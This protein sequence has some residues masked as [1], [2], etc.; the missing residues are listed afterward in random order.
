MAK[1]LRSF[2]SCGAFAVAIFT[3]CLHVLP[4][5]AVLVSTLAGSGG[6]GTVN[7]IGTQAS[8]NAPF[9][10]AISR[11]G[12]FALIGDRGNSQIRY[13]D[14]ISAQ[15]T[16]LASS[17][18]QPESIS[19]SPDDSF[20]LFTGLSQPYTIRK[21]DIATGIVTVLAGSSTSGTAD[22]FGTLATFNAPRGIAHS[23]DGTFAL[24]ADQ[25]SWR[26]RRIDVNTTNVTTVAGS[27]QGFFDGMGTNA[28][29]SWLMGV[30]IDPSGSYALIC[31]YGNNRIRR[32]DLVSA[33]VT[34]LAGSSQG[35]R[36]GVGG[37]AFFNEPVSVSID[38][39]GAYVLVAEFRNYRIRRIVISTAQVTTL[40]G[41]GAVSS[42]NGAGGQATFNEPTSIS[43]D[44]SGAFALLASGAGH[45]IR[46]I[47]L[48][49]PCP[50]A[51]FCSTGSSAPT[52]CST[53]SYCPAGSSSDTPCA[54]GLYCPSFSVALPCSAGYFCNATGLS[55]NNGLQFVCAAGRF[56]QAGA[57]SATGTGACQAG[58]YC[59]SGS[60]TSSGN[61]TCA[62]GFYCLSGA[63][64]SQQS[65]CTAGRYCNAGSSS[66]N[67]T[68][69]CQEGFYCPSGSSSARQNVCPAGNTCPTGT[70]YLCTPGYYC[71]NNTFS[72][73]S[74]NNTNAVLPQ[75]CLAAYY[76]PGGSSSPTGAGLCSGGYYCTAG[77][78][79]PTPPAAACSTG[80]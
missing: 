62:A 16:L 22:G 2:H 36:D 17:S 10:V 78:S 60:S 53:G 4:N 41:T 18:T 29:F 74:L 11:S 40:A 8:F 77:S 25:S 47:E 46:R 67:G 42:V 63:S 3:L 32:F 75:L 48:T 5:I 12:K 61:G 57:S 52:A 31:D 1:V 23:P 58:Y 35:Y 59:P 20:A 9:G 13:I 79:S 19:I 34:T 21:V 26:L 33:G 80:Y 15:V 49:V 68:G 45:F 27:N 7:G 6:P 55:T 54:A 56:C 73:S 70:G 69:V 65:Q 37:N 28:M 39:S 43:I 38:P 66:T 30:A 51:S 71:A 14:L 24:I 44:T 72:T 64:S 50:T 76:C